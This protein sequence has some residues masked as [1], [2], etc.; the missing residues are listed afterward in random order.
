M[1]EFLDYSFKT[2]L[3]RRVTHSPRS[4]PFVCAVWY[5]CIRIWTGCQTPWKVEMANWPVT[6]AQIT[7]QAVWEYWCMSLG[8]G[9]FMYTQ[10]WSYSTIRWQCIK[11]QAW[12]FTQ[13]GNGMLVFVRDTS[14]FVKYTSNRKLPS[15]WLHFKW[16]ARPIWKQWWR[17]W[18]P[19]SFRPETCHCI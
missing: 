17:P 1:F 6:P 5:T 9:T 12:N 14:M 18:C 15:L 13:E 8:G 3:I 10:S 11:W 2:E 4:S 7:C 19:W 16:K